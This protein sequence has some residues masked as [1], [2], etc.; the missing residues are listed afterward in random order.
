[1][2]LQNLL[3]IVASTLSM[4]FIWPQVFR[5]YHN[6]TVEGLAP[7]GALQGMS[8][9][10][11]WAVYGLAQT[12]IPL[13]GSNLLLAV[14]IA[15]LGVAMTRH[16]VLSRTVLSTV[17][18]VVLGVGFITASVS[19]SLVGILAFGVG[20]LSVLPQTVKVL[21]DP[22]LNGVSVSSNSLLFVT[23]CAW[24]SYGLTIGDTLVWL[25]NVLVIPCSAL[26]VVKARASQRRTAHVPV[27]AG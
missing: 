12:D 13:F 27:H 23:C 3:G 8:G 20:A 26:I 24:L 15:L 11:L 18:T 4:L 16:G 2:T 9:S 22:D 21:R 1:M 6:D 17:I 10:I 25:P 7:L 19:T 5:V 14:A